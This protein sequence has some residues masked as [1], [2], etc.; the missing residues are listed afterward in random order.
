MQVARSP[1]NSA[2]VSNNMVTPDYSLRRY[3]SLKDVPLDDAKRILLDH[4][5]L[6][7]R[8]LVD[9]GGPWF[10]IHDHINA[11]WQGFDAYVPPNGSYYLAHR[12][13]GEVVGTGAL[14]R[15]SETTAE[16][17]HLYVK[18]DMRGSGLGTA[19]VKQRIADAKEMGV[20]HLI[21]DTIKFNSELPALY[22]K[23]GFR[24][25]QTAELSYSAHV[26]PELSDFL[27]YF[28]MDL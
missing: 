22:K 27:F 1:S 2:T 25:V 19:L 3:A 10:D 8:R 6:Q 11:F 18:P 16:M 12:A 4:G 23:L 26:T 24:K 7:L 14:K 13:S 20:K 5:E 28:R 21:A 15:V 9:A 17:K